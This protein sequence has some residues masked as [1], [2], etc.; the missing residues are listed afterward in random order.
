MVFQVSLYLVAVLVSQNAAPALISVPTFNRTLPYQAEVQLLWPPPDLIGRIG[1][2]ENSQVPWAILPSLAQLPN[3]SLPGH[4][5]GYFAGRSYSAFGT[6]D[7]VWLHDSLI[8]RVPSSTTESQLLSRAN[9]TSAIISVVCD[10]IL[11]SD[12]HSVTW[13]QHSIWNIRFHS[14][15]WILPQT[16]CVLIYVLCHCANHYA[17]RPNRCHSSSVEARCS[18]TC[19]CQHGILISLPKPPRQIPKDVTPSLPPT[20]EAGLY[21]AL[22]LGSIN[23]TQAYFRC[24]LDASIQARSLDLSNRL[25]SIYSPC[26]LESGPA[27]NMSYAS[28]I[29]IPSPKDL[30]TQNVRSSPPCSSTNASNRVGDIVGN[31]TCLVW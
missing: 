22:D 12:V 15:V 7:G 8:Q 6:T 20:N 2:D 1:F 29:T 27:K 4:A 3:V 26:E 24:H 5:R 23:G 9:V 14:D 10:S 30:W 16:S 11:P 19:S 17:L 21:I 13:N 25:T 31:F 28:P 18:G